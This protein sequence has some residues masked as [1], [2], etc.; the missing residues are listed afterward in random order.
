MGQKKHKN[1]TEQADLSDG[2]PRVAVVGAV[3]TPFVRSFG[4]FERETPLG[5]SL[6]PATEVIARSGANAADIDEVI[7]GAVVPQTKNPNIARDIVLFA[8]LPKSIAGYTLNRACASSL[9][10]VQLAADAIKSGRNKMVLAGGVEVLSDV[11]ITFSDEARRFL[12]RLSRTK[13]IK[14]K[15]MML[16]E[17]NPKAFLPKPPA[18]AEPFTGFTMGEHGEQMA[19]KNDITRERQDEL[20]MRSHHRAAAAIE[21]GYLKDEIV[22]VWSGANKENFVDADNLVRADTSIEALAK[23]KPAFDKR[24]GTLTAGNSSALTDGASAVLLANA[25]YAEAHK[26]PILGYVVDSV[27]VAVDPKDQLLIGPAYAI[28]KLLA[29]HNLKLSD[30]GVFEIHE[31][32]AAQVL[33][34]LD[35]MSNTRFCQE[36]LGLEGAYGVIDPNK[37]NIDGG[38]IAYGHPFGA[39][40][41]RLVGRALRIAQ[42]TGSRYALVAICAAGGMGQAMLLEAPQH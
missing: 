12:T 41:G 35:A 34:C 11:P 28:P 4:V 39:T 21:K 22:P 40:G 8:G 37:M 38:S 14:E 23:L 25:D 32:F 18:L 1:G 15:L 6:R 27:A 5:L 19:V 20:A 29:R 9:Q 24:N 16:G 3:R 42:R 26:L 10:A 17:F 36:K 2:T 31:A 13:N 33:S 30:I 7:W